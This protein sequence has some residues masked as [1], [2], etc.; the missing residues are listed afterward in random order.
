MPCGMSAG[1]QSRE[2][3]KWWEMLLATLTDGARKLT[4]VWA[5]LQRA[6]DCTAHAVFRWPDLSGITML[7][8]LL[9]R[10]SCTRLCA[11]P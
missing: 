11:T 3:V 1:L 10:F 9:S 8:L 5:P 6:R 7:L 2:G 4:A